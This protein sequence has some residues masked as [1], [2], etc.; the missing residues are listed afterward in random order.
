MY[1][2]LS[3]GILPRIC[4]H[5][6]HI[7]DKHTDICIK[8]VARIHTHQDHSKDTHTHTHTSRP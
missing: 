8:T 3:I 6:D 7:K 4:T 1:V 2:E 5:Q